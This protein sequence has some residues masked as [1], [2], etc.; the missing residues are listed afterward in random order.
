MVGWCKH[1]HTLA[2]A[3]IEIILIFSIEMTEQI[4]THFKSIL[5]IIYIYIFENYEN[6]KTNLMK[7][8]IY[9]LVVCCIFSFCFEFEFA[10]AIFS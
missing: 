2:I 10:F 9:I 1:T 8:A 3:N 6:S 5:E 4:N 7:K